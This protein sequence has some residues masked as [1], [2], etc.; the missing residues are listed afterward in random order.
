[1]V[2]YQIDTEE[3]SDTFMARCFVNG[4]EAYDGEINLG[5]EENMIS[6]E[7]AVKLCLEHEIKRGN[8]V[9]KKEPI[10]ALRGEIYFVKFIINP[11]EDDVEPR[12]LKEEEEKSLDDWD[13]LLD[14]NLDYVPL[15]GEEELSP[16][17]C[18]MGRSSRNKKRAMKNLNFFYPEI[19]TSSSAGGH[20]TQEEA[21][22]KSISNQNEPKKIL[23]EIW[24]DKV[25]LDG[26]I[27]KEEKE[28]VKRIKGEALKEIDDPRAFIFPIRLEGQINENALADTGSDINT[29]SYRIYEQ[30]GREDMKKVD[31]GITMINHTQAKAIGILINTIGTHDDEVGSSRSKRSRQNETVEEVLLPHVHHE[32]LL[33]EGCNRDVKS[34]YNTRLAQLLPRHVCSPCVVNW[35]V[36]NRMGCDGEIDDMLRIR[37]GLYHVDELEEDGFND[38]FE[39]G[40]RSDEHFNAQEYWLIISREENLGLSRSHTSTIRSPILRVI[41][42][43][44]TY[45]LCQKTTGY[46]KIQKNDLWLLSMFDA[47]HQN[48][49]ANVAW[50]IARWMKRRGA[51]TQKES[52]ICCGQFISK[53]ARKC[54]VLTKDVVRSLSAPIYCRDLDTTPLRDLID[55]E[56]K[57][58]LEDPQPGVPRIGIPRPLRASIQDLYQEVF[59]HMVGVYSVPLQGAYNPPGY[60]Q[61]QYDQH[62]Q[63]YPPPPQ[64]PPQYRQQQ[65]D[66]E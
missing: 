24:K 59:E 31:R 26:K 4:L 30:L 16:F 43:M 64:Y 19:G 25:E 48:R 57:L 60:A 34:R 37:L 15:L 8:K 41:H 50:L 55:F 32:F 33:W 62:Y 52:Q 11:E 13:H 53:I 17:V 49:Y 58:I 3:V 29:M 5:V 47:R 65:D 35:D 22:K 54:R 14:F 6:N 23:D 46:D 28:A 42:K 7:Y 51:G 12:I 18:K 9:V 38:Y 56:G 36:M 39:G 40:L 10:V 21:A 1:M 20:L 63:Q 27:V 45:G 2:F 61:P 44:I 66:D